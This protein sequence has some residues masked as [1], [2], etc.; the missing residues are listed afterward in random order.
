MK[1]LDDSKPHEELTVPLPVRMSQN[2]AHL[3]DTVY[4]SRGDTSQSFTIVR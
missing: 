1:T 2:A 4:Q 3:E